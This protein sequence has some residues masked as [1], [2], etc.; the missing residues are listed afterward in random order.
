MDEELIALVQR[1]IFLPK[2]STIQMPKAE[3]GNY[4]T[5]M[6]SRS[7]S[8]TGKDGCSNASPHNWLKKHR[9]KHAICSHQEDYC[10]TCVEIKGS[11]Q[12]T[13]NCKKQF[14]GTLP[15]EFKKLE[16]KI[17]TKKK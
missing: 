5:R 9:P 3:V 7:Q 1:F 15:D 10:D 8:E 6:L 4:E 14:G 13:I 16:D 17:A 2:F 11:Q 12:T